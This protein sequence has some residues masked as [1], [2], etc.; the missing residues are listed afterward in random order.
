MSGIQTHST[1]LYWEPVFATF[2]EDNDYLYGLTRTMMNEKIGFSHI[3]YADKVL[4]YDVQGVLTDLDTH[5]RIVE[6]A[7]L[8]EP[9][10]NMQL[11]DIGEGVSLLQPF[12]VMFT[13]NTATQPRL[14]VLQDRRKKLDVTLGYIER[15]DPP[16]YYSANQRF[17]VTIGATDS[18][19]DTMLWRVRP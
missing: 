14:A 11:T 3:R 6:S 7:D 4:R 10:V 13:A 5:K 19:F 18:T 2:F 17:A 16:Q 1:Q 8:C 9:A 15:V 12:H